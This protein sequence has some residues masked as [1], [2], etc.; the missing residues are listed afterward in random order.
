MNERLMTNQRRSLP[1]ELLIAIPAFALLFLAFFPNY[2]VNGMFHDVT[3]VPMINMIL[4][5]LAGT[6]IATIL[7]VPTLAR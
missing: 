5:F 6:M 1:R 4:Y 7:L 2:F 3:L